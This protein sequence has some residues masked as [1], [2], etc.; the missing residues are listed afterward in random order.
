M[1]NTTLAGAIALTDLRAAAEML[2]R[3]RGEM[4]EAERCAHTLIDSVTAIMIASDAA[5]RWL[6]K[7]QSDAG[8]FRQLISL[9]DTE[10]ARAA[11]TAGHFRALV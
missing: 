2:G 1:P 8:E 11:A 6:A 9:I 10:R 7:E 3:G 5:Q 4:L